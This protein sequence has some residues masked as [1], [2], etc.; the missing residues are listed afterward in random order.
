M[1]ISFGTLT[2]ERIHIVKTSREVCKWS[3]LK[4]KIMSEQD[5]KRTVPFYFVVKLAMPHIWD[6]YSMLKCS[7]TYIMAYHELRKMDVANSRYSMQHTM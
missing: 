6:T 5:L 7:D 4:R 3:E 1:Q 2:P